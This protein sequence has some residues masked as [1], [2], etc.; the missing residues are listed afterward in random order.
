MGFCLTQCSSSQV[1]LKGASYH[2]YYSFS[3]QTC[4]NRANIK[5]ADDSVIVSLLKEGETSHGP[6][7]DD[8]V[9]WCEESYLQLNISK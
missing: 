7:I 1:F 5:Y 4:G 9:Q 2:P 8:F 3:M 6:V